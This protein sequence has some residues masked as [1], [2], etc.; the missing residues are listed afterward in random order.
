MNQ[1]NQAA[2]IAQDALNQLDAG[3][4]TAISMQ[5]LAPEGYR[6]RDHMTG[7]EY[8]TTTCHVC[9]Q[10]ALVVGYMTRLGNGRLSD[11]DV[12]SDQVMAIFGYENF[13]LI[14][15]CFEGFNSGE[16]VHRMSR[17]PGRK[18]AS[19][20]CKAHTTASPEASA[21]AQPAMPRCGGTT[22][23]SSKRSPKN[24]ASS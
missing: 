11:Y 18:T 7:D 2:Q 10:G 8:K 17:Q 15:A 5:Y 22:A 1:P 3:K 20:S 6:N 13:D 16:S 21:G 19:S 14:E 24:T 23:A 9:A 4:L 12:R